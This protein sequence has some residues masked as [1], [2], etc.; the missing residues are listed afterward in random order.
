M[1]DL[2]WLKANG[3]DQA[4]I[5]AA[6]AG[7]PVI[8]LCGGY[9]ILG[10]QL[11]DRDGVAGDAGEEGGLG[12]LPVKTHFE[13][14]KIVRQVT[15]FCGDRRWL[16]Y[17]MHM[18]QT[19]RTG[20]SEPLHVVEDSSGMREEG[21]RVG[22]VSGTYLHGWF[23]VP[24]VRQLVAS[25]AGISGYKAYPVSWMEKRQEIYD[26]M[27]AHLMAHVDLQPIQRYLGL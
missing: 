18:G 27:A 3:L 12:L 7:I 15:A 13:P 19:L 11:T 25:V 8:G 1:A 23:E 16:A 2:R 22:K 21:V 9:Q 5:S 26:R 24:E 20:P 10:E 4:I 17:E 14:R 6:R